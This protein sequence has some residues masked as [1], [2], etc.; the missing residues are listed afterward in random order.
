[1][2]WPARPERRRAS[3]LGTRRLMSLDPEPYTVYTLYHIP[4]TLYPIPYTLYPIPY[5][6]NPI[7]YIPYT[8]YPI[9]Y[10]LHPTP[11]T[12][13]P[14]PYTIHIPNTTCPIPCT[15]YPTHHTAN[16]IL[17]TLD[18]RLLNQKRVRMSNYPA[19]RSPE[20]QGTW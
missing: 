14:E 6:L 15:L 3:R 9:P 10:T 17:K 1:M 4:Y 20:A 8:L 13:Y 5:T 16:H 2:S 7:P 12:L 18:L 11:Y 19:S